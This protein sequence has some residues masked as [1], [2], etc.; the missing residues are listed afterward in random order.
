MNKINMIGLKFGKLLV[1]GE[2]SKDRN[3]HITYMCKCD[4]GKYH[5]ANGDHLRRI[6]ITHCGCSKLKGKI[7]PQFKGYEELSKNW[8]I[9]HISRKSRKRRDVP[10][11]INPEYL[12]NLFIK[13]DRKC[14]LS[15]LD[16]RI[17][18]TE[19][20]N[21]ASVD[22]IDNTKGYI[23]TGKQKAGANKRDAH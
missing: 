7:H 17:D 15:G 23:V 4:C 22:R 12:W 1:I 11:N 9:N 5:N 21:T 8:F 2:H 20:Y 16:I 18:N 13:Q 6:K 3:G 19:K 14:I 10:I